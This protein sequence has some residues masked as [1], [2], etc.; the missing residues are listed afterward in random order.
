MNKT[1]Y[2][3]GKRESVEA[4]VLGIYLFV[5]AAGGGIRLIQINSHEQ[6]WE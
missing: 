5:A 1:T 4:M 2:L 6:I 3:N